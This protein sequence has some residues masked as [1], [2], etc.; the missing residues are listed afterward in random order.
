MNAAIDAPSSIT[1][2]NKNDQFVI[3]ASKRQD[4]NPNR[5]LDVV[6]HG[7]LNKI[8]V[9]IGGTRPIL[10]DHRTAAK[11][12]QQSPDY[13]KGQPIRLLS[14]STGM[15]DTGF[16]QNLANKMGVSVQAPS[17]LVWAFP[18]GKMVV[19]PR[20]STNPRSSLYG[21]PDLRNIGEFKL[22]KPK[23]N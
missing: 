11:L 19:A 20:R 13:V 1:F 22:F 3:N 17:N 7:A 16:A 14:C 5:L 6:A 18:S 23:G 2:M 9:S 4:I 21:Q 8:E 12:I 10:V 15:C